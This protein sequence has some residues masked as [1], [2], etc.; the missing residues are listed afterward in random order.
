[1]TNYTFK[2]SLLFSTLWSL[3]LASLSTAS[4]NIEMLCSKTQHKD[5]EPGLG[6]FWNSLH[7]WN[8]Q[9]EAFSPEAAHIL[10][11]G[12][13]VRGMRAASCAGGA[14]AVSLCDAVLG[15]RWLCQLPCS[16]FHWL[17]S[18]VGKGPCMLTIQPWIH[19][20]GLVLNDIH[21]CQKTL[22][23]RKRPKGSGALR[24][25]KLAGFYIRVAGEV[26]T[27]QMV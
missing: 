17:E 23:P 12:L 25:A 16:L 13:W 10:L 22:S 15:H 6:H 11:A 5:W 7:W 20:L 18:G 8:Q 4:G 26:I 21:W 3:M 1:M 14:W 19:M 9:A 24:V 2:F 27:G